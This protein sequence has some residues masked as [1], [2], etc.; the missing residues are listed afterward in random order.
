MRG[1]RHKGA[2]ATTPGSV[3]R[4][5]TTAGVKDRTGVDKL[6][7]MTSPISFTFGTRAF[8]HP[9]DWDDTVWQEP[10]APRR[11]DPSSLEWLF[12]GFLL[13]MAIAALPLVGIRWTTP[14]GAQMGEVLDDVVLLALPVLVPLPF[15]F[16]GC[17]GVLASNAASRTPSALASF[18]MAVVIGFAGIHAAVV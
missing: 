12:W 10:P 2:Y 7:G 5:S 4:Y 16:A 14:E 13:C 17:V 1:D 11:A 18:A 6:T 8:R 15:L 9:E 3:R